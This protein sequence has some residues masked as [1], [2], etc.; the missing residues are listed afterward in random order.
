M[1]MHHRTYFLNV[2]WAS[3]CLIYSSTVLAYNDKKGLGVIP[4]NSLHA[5]YTE[6]IK[7]LDINWYYNWGVFPEKKM[8]SEIQFVP[9]IGNKNAVKKVNNVTSYPYVLLFN[10]PDPVQ[11]SSHID[12]IT[13]K[14][15]SNLFEGIISKLDKVKIISPA[16]RN[17][18]NNWLHDFNRI[19]GDSKRMHAI[20]MHWYGEPDIEKFKKDVNFIH[21]KYK[22]KLWITEF[23]V[24]IP[25]ND[26][27]EENPKKVYRFMKE[28]LTFLNQQTYVEKYSWFSPKDSSSESCKLRYDVL[29]NTDG[30]LTDLGLLYSKY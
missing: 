21:N 30:S 24:R 8:P 27:S 12:I 16:P 11:V 23:A 18:W 10:E 17:P 15:A 4:G 22:N 28:A 7:K 25:C 9:M 19:S 6:G 20:A 14:D 13:P 26:N 2:F 1:I 5:G 29:I 3:I